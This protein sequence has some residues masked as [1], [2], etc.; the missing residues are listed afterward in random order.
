MIQKLTIH[1]I[2]VFAVLFAASSDALQTGTN[3]QQAS[4]NERPKLQ[5]F[6]ELRSKIR[7]KQ[8]K[9]DQLFGSIP[10]GFPEL[11]AQYEEQIEEMKKDLAALRGQIK[12]SVIDAYLEQPNADKLVNTELLNL[13]KFSLSPAKS[14][15]RFDPATALEVSKIIFEHGVNDPQIQYLA[16]RACLPLH[17][18]DEAQELLDKIQ[19]NA[20]LNSE[21]IT[22]FEETVTKWKRELDLRRAEAGRNDLPRVKFETTNG[23]ILVELFE[24]HAPQTVGNFINLVESEYYNGLIF[25]LVEPGKFAQTGCKDGNGQTDPGYNIYCECYQDQIRHHF[26]GSLSMANSGKDTGGAQFFIMQQPD[27]SIDGKYTVFGR[28]VEGLDVVFNLNPCNK[29]GVV[30]DTNEPSKIIKA[31]VVRKRQKDYQPTK[32][33]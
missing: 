14:W 26:A 32:V 18:F 17:E 13:V 11:Q 15:Q 20:E 10:I 23:T 30:P 8:L 1:F 16:F 19:A 9:I 33:N 21:V 27:V 4:E 25:H 7:R 12:Q 28:V 6:R 22:K 3:E 29:T 5:A 31:E 24:D 2:L